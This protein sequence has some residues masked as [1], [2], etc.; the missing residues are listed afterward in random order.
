MLKIF[1]VRLQ[2]YVNQELPNGGEFR[3]DRRTRDQFANS[4]WIIEKAREFQKTISFI[5][6]TKAFDCVD[7]NKLCK[8]LQVMGIPDHLCLLR[9]LYVGQETT[10]RTEHGTQTGSKLGKGFIK[11]VY[12]HPTY[13]TYMQRTSCEMLGWMKHKLE[14]RLLGEISAT[15]CMQMIPPLW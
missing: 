6:Y 14:S 12:C 9:N 11:A 13:S 2:Q 1:Q 8:I 3:K 5:H 10:V 7:H 4:I 15:S